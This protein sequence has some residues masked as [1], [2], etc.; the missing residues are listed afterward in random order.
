M[1]KREVSAKPSW[2]KKPSPKAVA[3]AEPSDVG[4]F[5]IALWL[6]LLLATAVIVVVAIEV[7]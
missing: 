7:I 6:V 1:P 5:W 3:K 4:P 2:T